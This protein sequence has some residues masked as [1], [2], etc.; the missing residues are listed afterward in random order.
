MCD[1]AFSC[2]LQSQRKPC[3]LLYPFFVQVVDDPGQNNRQGQQN[4]FFHDSLAQSHFFFVY[5]IAWKP[6]P[7][8]FIK[9][10]AKI[11]HWSLSNNRA[12][13]GFL[14]SSQT[15]SVGTEFEELELVDAID[16]SSSKDY[17]FE[18]IPTNVLSQAESSVMLIQNS[19]TSCP[20]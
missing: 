9:R 17:I 2:F 13:N 7:L 19:M 11:R 12:E 20:K 10:M 15:R 1:F 18:D 6:L 4:S 16:K 8:F 14:S 3:I 5:H